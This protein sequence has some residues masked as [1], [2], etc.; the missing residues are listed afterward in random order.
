[1]RFFAAF[2]FTTRDVTRCAGFLA[3]FLARAAGAFL[4]PPGDFREADLAGEAFAA[5]FPL[6]DRALR[7]P[8][9]AFDAPPEVLPDSLNVVPL[10]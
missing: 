4:R 2:F 5:F 1:V 3:T 9:F 8:A 6:C 7:V 10:Q